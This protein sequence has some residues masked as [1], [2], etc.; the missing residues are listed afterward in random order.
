MVLTATGTPHLAAALGAM[1]FAVSDWLIGHDRFVGPGL[2]GPVAVMVTYH[3]GQALL[4]LGL[5][6]GG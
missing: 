2:G 1:T 6:H 3:I 5:A 4:I